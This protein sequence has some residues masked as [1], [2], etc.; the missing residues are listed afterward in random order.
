M[1]KVWR[2]FVRTVF[3]SYERGS[4]P[5]DLM[6]IAILV[7]VLITPRRWFH[8]HPQ[9][10]PFEE[11]GVQ[12]VVENADGRTRVYR[13]DAKLLPP[14]KRT[15]KATP[16]LERETHDILGENVDDLKGRTFQVLQIN[17]V[18]ADDG[19]VQSYEVTVRP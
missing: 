1:N 12:L 11:S 18:R 3:W 9:S 5:Y 4:W 8:D 16:E 15:Q 7:F 6:V 2:G 14:Q 13:L 17:P 10:S 19:S